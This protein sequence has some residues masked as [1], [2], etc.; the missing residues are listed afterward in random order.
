MFC[1][2]DGVDFEIAEPEPFDKKWF[3]HKF[4]GAGLRYETVISLKEGK[5]IWCNGP[6][7]CG[8]FPDIKIFNSKLQ[9]YLL[10]SEKLIADDGYT[11]DCFIKKGGLSDDG[12]NFHRL[13]RARHETFHKRLRHFNILKQKYRHNLSDH[14]KYFFAV[15]NIVNNTLNF[16]SPLFTI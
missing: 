15:L 4:K 12:E 1:S 9:H 5:V 16:G 10:S 2:I 7:P 13:V 6:Y 11:G 14:S 8:S 3:S